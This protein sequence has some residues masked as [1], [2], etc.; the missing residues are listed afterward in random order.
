MFVSLIVVIIVV[1][2]LKYN[3]ND[4]GK[5]RHIIQH[6]HD[7]VIVPVQKEFGHLY[8]SLNDVV[9]Y[10]A[11]SPSYTID[12]KYIYMCIRQPGQIETFYDMATLTHVLLH[13]LAHVMA[14][15]YGHNSDFTDAF[16]RLKVFRDKELPNKIAPVGSPYCGV[17][18]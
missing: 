16:K 12:K 13:E 8:P 5:G 2:L 17:L 14:K 6:L 15:T 3:V 7:T 11:N 10:E 4:D 1:I 9:I 18:L